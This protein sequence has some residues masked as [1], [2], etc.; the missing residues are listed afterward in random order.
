LETYLSDSSQLVRILESLPPAESAAAPED[1]S[2][3]MERVLR[4]HRAK[5]SPDADVG[6]EVFQEPDWRGKSLALPADVTSLASHQWHGKVASFK[7]QAGHSAVLFEEE[8]FTGR[9]V[10]LSGSSG[11]IK[12]VSSS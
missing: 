7:L 8:G 11:S 2:H 12:Q 9:Q 4:L 10:A 3:E 6:I 1:I 5:R